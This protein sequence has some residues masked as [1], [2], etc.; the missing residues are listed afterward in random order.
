MQILKWMS[1]Q[2]KKIAEKFG[3]FLVLL[4]QLCPTLTESQ[5]AAL[6][7]SSESIQYSWWLFFVF[8]SMV[9]IFIWLCALVVN[10]PQC[11]SVLHLTCARSDM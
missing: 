4:V 8:N 3:G 5:V 11:S 9:Q 7:H 1:H 2:F 10:A 6:S